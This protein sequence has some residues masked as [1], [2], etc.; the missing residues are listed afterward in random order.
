[1]AHTS[2]LEGVTLRS[3]S[4]SVNS[5]EYDFADDN[6]PDVASIAD[7][8]SESPLPGDGDVDSVVS[9]DFIPI[10]DDHVETANQKEMDSSEIKSMEDEMSENEQ[11]D[12]LGADAHLSKI[13]SQLQY[14]Y[15]QMLQLFEDAPSPADAPTSVLINKQLREHS[16]AIAAMFGDDIFALKEMLHARGKEHSEMRILIANE[17]A[18]TKDEKSK[19]QQR[20]RQ[21]IVQHDRVIQ[22]K[23]AQIRQKI[24]ELTTAL[25]RERLQKQR[26]DKTEFDMAVALEDAQAEVHNLAMKHRVET[27]S[28][29][30]SY[31][32]AMANLKED[33]NAAIFVRDQENR[34]KVNEINK[35]HVKMAKMAKDDEDYTDKLDQKHE[36]TIA[37][38][39]QEHGEAIKTLE[40]E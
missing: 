32:Q 24:A 29:Q 28:L 23:E 36:E 22:I 9:D 6:L 21:I 4:E 18:S 20:L 1:M 5:A 10:S 40:V 11:F 37:T 33:F 39:K 14:H 8:G 12:C 13:R 30:N 16:R 25:T 38:L 17:R 19:S 34:K 15:E 27:V 7:A 3:D 35:L 31:G 26:S 2:E